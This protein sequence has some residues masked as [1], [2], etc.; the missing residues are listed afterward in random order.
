MRSAKKYVGMGRVIRLA[1]TASTTTARAILLIMVPVKD[2]LMNKGESLGCNGTEQPD[3]STML[4]VFGKLKSSRVLPSFYS[5]P[6]IPAAT[7]TFSPKGNC[8]GLMSIASFTLVEYTPGDS[9]T[10]L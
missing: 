4:V 8:G 1:R 6:I 9:T 10:A 3:S 7:E 5:A 2:E